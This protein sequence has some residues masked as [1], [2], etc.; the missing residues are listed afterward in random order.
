MAGPNRKTF[1]YRIIRRGQ[2][3]SD[4]S[5]IRKLADLRMPVPATKIDDSLRASAEDIADYQRSMGRR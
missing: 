2:H 5:R 4:P 1:Q 3:Q